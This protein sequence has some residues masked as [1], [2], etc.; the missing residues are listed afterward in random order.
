MITKQERFERRAKI[1]LFIGITV[2]VMA[3]GKITILSVIN[4][5]F[6]SA[7][8]WAVLWFMYVFFRDLSIAL[9]WKKP[10]FEL[11][12]HPREDAEMDIKREEMDRDWDIN[13]ANPAS[14]IYEEDFR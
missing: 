6:Y 7:F 2:T 11:P 14:P 10:E 9:G 5:L 8:L 3:T 13:P 4:N 12:Q 1:L